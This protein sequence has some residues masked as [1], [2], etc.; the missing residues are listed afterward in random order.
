MVEH[1]DCS[2]IRRQPAEPAVKLVPVAD[3]EQVVGRRRSVD[4]QHPKNRCPVALVRRL[5]HALSDEESS[6]PRVEA[7]RIAEAL[8]VTPGDHQR[9]LD[10]ILG[11]IDVA[12]E[13]MSDREEL[14]DSRPDQ[15]D[16]RLPTSASSRLDEISIHCEPLVAPGGGAVHSS[17]PRWTVE[18]SFFAAAR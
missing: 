11:P 18:R 6:Q 15:V 1:Q 8:Q 7:V 12:E 2:L 9:I 3:G 14:V 13:S 4:R 10:G 5:V 16:K 17:W